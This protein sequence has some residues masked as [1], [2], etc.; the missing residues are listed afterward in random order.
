[1]SKLNDVRRKP[2]KII[3]EDGKER[4]LKFTLNAMAE[5]EDKFGSV[6]NAF[7]AVENHSF[8]AVRTVLWAGFI[9]AEP[10]LTELEVGNLIDM[11]N[12]EYLMEQLNAAFSTDMPDATPGESGVTAQPVVPS[13]KYPGPGGNDPNA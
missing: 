11:T 6:E 4:E 2:I 5:L 9:H 10:T 7:K 1:M 13:S 12:I 3:L 8:K